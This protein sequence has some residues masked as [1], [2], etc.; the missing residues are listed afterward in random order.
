M[1][2]HP[3][4]DIKKTVGTLVTLDGATC[5]GST[6]YSGYTCNRST[7]ELGT[8]V[9]GLVVPLGPLKQGIL[10]TPGHTVTGHLVHGQVNEAPNNRSMTIDQQGKYTGHNSEKQALCT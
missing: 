4:L 7:C 1:L 2:I 5:E 9:T 6:C 10:E 3:K 8:L